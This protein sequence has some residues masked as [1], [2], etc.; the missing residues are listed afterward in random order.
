[1]IFNK[2]DRTCIVHWLRFTAIAKQSK[3]K[4]TTTKQKT[5]NTGLT[6]F[7][8]KFK[9]VVEPDWVIPSFH[10]VKNESVTRLIAP[11]ITFLERWTCFSAVYR[12]QFL[13]PPSLDNLCWWEPWH[14]EILGWFHLPCFLFSRGYWMMHSRSKPQQLFSSIVIQGFSMHRV[15][16][17]LKQYYFE[18]FFLLY[19]TSF[20]LERRNISL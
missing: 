19:L 20:L 3:I 2:P 11:Q 4:Q 14:P 18:N 13:V 17:S 7:L 6:S 8:L 9:L 12:V 1:M 15:R 16:I 10:W 5:Q